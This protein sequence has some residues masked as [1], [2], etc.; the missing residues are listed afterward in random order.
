MTDLDAALVLLSLKHSPSQEF[1]QSS[2]SS[3]E[4]KNMRQSPEPLDRPSKHIKLES[5]SSP[6]SSYGGEPSPPELYAEETP[7]GGSSFGNTTANLTHSFRVDPQG[8]RI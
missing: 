3:G 2:P 7:A 8:K 4:D 5:M 6:E 1:N